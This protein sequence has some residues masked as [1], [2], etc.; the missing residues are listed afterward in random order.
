MCLKPDPNHER[1]CSTNPSW[2]TYS[3]RFLED[4]SLSASSQ[5][6]TVV[7]VS[8]AEN[9]LRWGWHARSKVLRGGR[10]SGNTGMRQEQIGISKGGT[11]L[12]RKLRSSRRVHREEPNAVTRSRATP[13]TRAPKMYPRPYYSGNPAACR[14]GG[15]AHNPVFASLSNFSTNTDRGESMTGS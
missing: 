12:R 5:V 6:Y 1:L 11:K 4:R 9:A 10:Y 14:V 13:I 2:F 7:V 3:G 8:C 15:D